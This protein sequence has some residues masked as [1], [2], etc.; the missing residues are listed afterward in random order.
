[1][2]ASERVPVGRAHV[3]RIPLRRGNGHLEVLQWARQNGCPWDDRTCWKRG[4]GRRCC[5]GPWR[6]LN[7]SGQPGS[8]EG[9]NPWLHQ[10]EWDEQACSG[11]APR[12][13]V[14]P[15]GAAVGA[16]RTEV[17]QWLHQNG[18]WDAVT[19]TA[20]AEGGHLEVLQWARQN[21]CPWNEDDV[22]GSGG[23][24][25]NWCPWH[26]EV[27]QWARANGCPWNEKTC[28]AAASEGHLEVLQWARANGCP[29]NE[30]T[31]SEA[32]QFGHLRVL[33]WAHQNGC[34]WN[35]ETCSEAARKGT[36]R[37]CSGRVRT[38]A[39]GTRGR[40]GRGGGRAPGGAPVG[41]SERVPVERM[42]VRRGGAA[43][44]LLEVLQWAHQN[45][46]PWDENVLG[47]GGGRRRC[48]SGPTPVERGDVQGRGGGR[49]PVP[50][51]ARVPGC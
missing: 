24:R 37:C 26:L 48:C 47:R 35:E 16:C 44:G 20:A 33:Q 28:R 32:A 49:P 29:W 51:R 8:E 21:G 38:G 34:P 23:A 50:D 7:L 43:E 15:G 36:W 12:G 1:M 10:N 42:D 17:L 3:G 25:Q 18:W 19:C 2:V 9:L 22:L 13:G 14:A 6:C 5:S 4:G 41:A 45:G 40:A 31:C 30:Y 39:R 27:L 11:G 46:C